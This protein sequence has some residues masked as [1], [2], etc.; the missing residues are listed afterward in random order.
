ME[1]VRNRLVSRAGEV[2]P[3]PTKPCSESKKKLSLGSEV[4]LAV[5][6]CGV[7]M[8]ASLEM[9]HRIAPEHR[10][11]QQVSSSW[12]PPGRHSKQCGHDESQRTKTSAAVG[13]QPL[14]RV[15]L[16]TLLQKT[17]DHVLQHTRVVVRERERREAH[18]VQD[19]AQRP[20]VALLRVF[21]L[22]V[23]KEL[24]RCVLDRASVSATGRAGGHLSKR[25]GRS[26]VAQQG[27]RSVPTTVMPL[28]Q[29]VR[30]FQ[31]PVEDALVVQVLQAHQDVQQQVP[32]LGDRQGW[33]RPQAIL[34]DELLQRTTV[35]VL[36][37]DEEEGHQ[38]TEGRPARELEPGVLVLHH[39]GVME[40]LKGFH[41]AY[42]VAQPRLVVSHS[43]LLHGIVSKCQ[44]VQ[45]MA[46]EVHST[47]APRPQGLGLNEEAS[48]VARVQK[49]WRHT[50]QSSGCGCLSFCTTFRGH[51]C[52][53]G[54][55]QWHLPVLQKKRVRLVRLQGV[56]TVNFHLFGL[57]IHGFLRLQHRGVHHVHEL[58]DVKV[59]QVHVARLVVL[60]A[61]V[62]VRQH[63]EGLRD[64]LEF[65]LG[66]WIVKVF[67]G[68]RPQ[69]PFPVGTFDVVGL[70]VPRHTQYPVEVC[71]CE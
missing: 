5:R 35:A 52:A 39:V 34:P 22:A 33:L 71:L 62:L 53:N 23:L 37:E 9:S 49:P 50:S 43:H 48:I 3:W 8:A 59:L 57:E 27:T 11:V 66:V 20:H 13:R 21:T 42:H 32:H 15:A 18:G 46:A 25:H 47:K 65:Q 67:V 51:R 45:D 4:W 64:S 44:V 14:R 69:R 38:R 16:V 40:T 60:L 70:G 29:D 68:M 26:E 24:G 54:H 36:H 31:I 6:Q 17:S 10:V 7:V 12:P 30:R 56:A 61:L 63:G 28:Q 19:H 58:L 1:S 55:V 2:G 41:L